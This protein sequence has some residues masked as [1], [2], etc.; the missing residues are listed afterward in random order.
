M[1]T[2]RPGFSRQKYM[3]SPESFDPWLTKNASI[4]NEMASTPRINF[5]KVA[6]EFP[7]VR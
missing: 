2:G 1:Q 3:S 7:P 5:V 6:E 4:T